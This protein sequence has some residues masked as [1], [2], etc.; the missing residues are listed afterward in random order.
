MATE[1][2]FFYAV[3]AARSLSFSP[4][5]AIAALSVSPASHENQAKENGHK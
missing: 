3:K 2:I 5:P 1:G 4:E